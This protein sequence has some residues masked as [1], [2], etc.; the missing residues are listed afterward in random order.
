MSQSQSTENNGKEVQGITR[1]SVQGFKSLYN[2]CSI[3]IRPLT[4]L[5]GANSSGKSSIMQPLLLMK[6]TLEATYDPGA[7]LLNGP[8]V[9]FTLFEQF[10][11]SFAGTISTDIFSAELEISC[12]KSIKIQFQKQLSKEIEINKTIYQENKATLT[13]FAGMN[14]SDVLSLLHQRYVDRELGQ[15]FLK[16]TGEMV[17][18]LEWSIVR[19]RCFLNI[20]CKSIGYTEVGGEKVEVPVTLYDSR[21][22]TSLF[23]SHIRKLIHVPGL[24]SKPERT[25]PTTAVGAE[26]TGIFENYVASVINYWQQKKDEQL[27]E[28]GKFLERLGLTWKIIAIR[29]NDVQIELRVGRL[30]NS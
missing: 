25:Y 13:V 19:E 6:Q 1:I 15:I 14:R 17:D 12:K 10:L 3:E 29:V 2:E 8:N 7:L 26:F 5:A 20:D 22:G 9:G 4:I 28:L 27:I 30:P 18:K 23:E 24:R 16:G 21:S 11:P